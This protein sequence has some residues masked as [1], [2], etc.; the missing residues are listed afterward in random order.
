LGGGSARFLFLLLS[1]LEL[2]LFRFVLGLGPFYFGIGSSLLGSRFFFRRVARLC[3]VTR[4][5]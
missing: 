5:L 1:L 4:L 2:L 3:G